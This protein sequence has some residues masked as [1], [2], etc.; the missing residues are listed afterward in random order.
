MA[1]A[2]PALVRTD[3]IESDRDL[4]RRHRYGDEEAFEEVY[5]RFESMVYNLALRMGGNEAEAADCTQETFLRVFR[6]LGKFRGKSNLKTWVFRIA[7]NC[8]RSRYRKK[9]TRRRYLD[10]GGEELIERTADSGRSPEQR[11]VAAELSEHVQGALSQL[12]PVYREA[13]ILRDLQGLSYDEMATVLGVKLGTVRSRIARGREQLR[14]VLEATA[15][16]ES[17]SCE[18]DEPEQVETKS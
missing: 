3:L 5:E 16:I 11:V 14:T 2:A 7:L 18:G 10:F 15:A 8:C 1:T 6:Y 12:R 9:S 13:V 17:A 4:A